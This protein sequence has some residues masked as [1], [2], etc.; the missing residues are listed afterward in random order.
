MGQRAV[1]EATRK[2]FGLSSFS[3]STVCRSFKALEQSILKAM[4]GLPMQAVDFGGVGSGKQ[5]RFPSVSDTAERRSSMSMFLKS[6][7]DSNDAEDID[8][9][10]CTIV[11]NWYNKYSCLLI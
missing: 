10:S 2:K 7:A 5:R 4:E 1:A 6:L 9:Y 3:H 8:R 11:N